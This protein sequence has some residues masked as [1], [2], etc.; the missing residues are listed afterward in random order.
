MV[1]PFKGK[2]K[3]SNLLNSNLPTGG[4]VWSVHNEDLNRFYLDVITG[5][6]IVF[7]ARSG[8]INLS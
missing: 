7:V 8:A 6:I 3:Y 2:S 1:P 5:G 4:L